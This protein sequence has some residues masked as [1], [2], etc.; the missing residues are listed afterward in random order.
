MGKLNREELEWTA[1]GPGELD[2]DVFGSSE[3]VTLSFKGMGD[4]IRVKTK[5]VL[6]KMTKADIGCL[7]EN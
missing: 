7:K 6:P 5:D 1:A 2:F 4:V 3:G